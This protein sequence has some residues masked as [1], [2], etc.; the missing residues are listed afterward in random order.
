[1]VVVIN[2]TFTRTRD[3]QLQS[4]TKKKQSEM[5]MIFSGRRHIDFCKE[6]RKNRKGRNTNNRFPAPNLSHI[7]KK[8]RDMMNQVPGMV[9]ETERDVHRF[10]I[11]SGESRVQVS[12]NSAMSSSVTVRLVVLRSN[13]YTKAF[14]LGH[15]RTKSSS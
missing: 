14:Q 6:E 13:I 9:M 10:V 2:S 8:S 12:L 15:M 5:W 7:P 1:M 4:V 11:H 3:C